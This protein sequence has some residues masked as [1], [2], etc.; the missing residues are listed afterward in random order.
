MNIQI[1]NNGS[2]STNSLSQNIYE[3]V[4]NSFLLVTLL[5]FSLCSYLY[6]Y[7]SENIGCKQCSNKNTKMNIFSCGMMS[8]VYSCMSVRISEMANRNARHLVVRLGGTLWPQTDE[9]NNYAH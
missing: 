7:F 4:R 6:F 2:Q 3:A 9:I 8:G 1:K 5:V